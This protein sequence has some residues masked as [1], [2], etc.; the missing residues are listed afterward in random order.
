MKNKLK[1]GF[2]EFIARIILKNRITILGVIFLLTIFL[3]LQWKN[4][5]FSFTEANL[6]PDDNIVNTESVS[7]THLD[8]YKRQRFNC[9]KI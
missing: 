7:Y 3:G 6:L 4:I 9:Y 2:W 1:V 8:V 5:R